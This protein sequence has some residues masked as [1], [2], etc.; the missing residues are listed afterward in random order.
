VEHLLKGDSQTYTLEKRYLRKD[1]SILWVNITVSLVRTAAG[2]PAH[3]IAVIE[4]ITQRKQTEAALRASEERYRVVTELISDYAYSFTV[5]PDGS[6]MHEWLTE[7][8]YR[9]ITGYTREEIDAQG[10]YGLFHPDDVP[11]VE[12]SL[13]ALLRGESS[14]GEVRIITK[15]GEVRWLHIYRRPLWDPIQGRVVQVFGVAQDIT[16]RKRADEVLR[17]TNRMLEASRDT[18][19][20]LIQ[21]IP[22]GIQVF[23]ATGLCTDVNQ[24]HL[25][26]FGVPSRDQLVGRYNLF[27]DPMA[28]SVGTSAGARRALAGEIVQLGD[29]T[30]DFTRA[31][32]R[33]AAT[34]GRR[35][36]SVTFYPVTD[37]SGQIVHIVAL[38][39]DTTERRR[40]ESQ[41]LELAVEKE[42]VQMLQHFIRDTSHDLRTPLTTIK[43][44][45]YL[46]ERTIDD[47]G[48]RERYITVI[49]DQASRLHQ[50]L[51]D[52]LG[53]SRLD[54][55]SIEEFSFEM[56]SLNLLL[57]NMVAAHKETA[58][59]KKSRLTL[60][61]QP[62]LPPILVD[63]AQVSRALGNILTNAINYTPDGG[64]ISVH[65]YRQDNRIG[66]EIRDN[67]IGIHPEHLARIFDRFF[68]ADAA[69]GTDAGGVGL[70]L[71][72]ARRI[73]EAHGGDIEVESEL[74]QGT[75]VRVWLPVVEG[76][77]D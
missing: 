13:D 15:Q 27:D 19:R 75:T 6:F 64:Q 40:A 77:A 22:I 56:R 21:Q 50:L 58:D 2:D 63:D 32:P 38:N 46:L 23:D 55:A 17:T 45:L 14:S 72:I 7:D 34:T 12:R 51:D 3:F 65:A 24:A 26:I 41:Q 44:S 47:P 42:R 74:G 59:R 61:V 71:T 29:L 69:R 60:S 48:K 9:R 20:R 54:K 8:S 30:F 33:Y 36:V 62:N 1:Q 31:D 35:T 57:Q 53:M 28:A 16:E 10:K 39:Q 11:S 37:D 66:V 76:L 73:I 18:L 68:R 43:T 52:L 4:D 70:G 5:E 49:G 67:G 25:D